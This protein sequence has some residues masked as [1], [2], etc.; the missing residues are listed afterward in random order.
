MG[1]SIV[2][3]PVLEP[4][5]LAELKKQLEIA[6]TDTAHDM[7]LSRL[8]TRARRVVEAQT[9][10]ALVAQTWLITGP[11]FPAGCRNMW[12]PRPPL[13]SVSWVKYYDAAGIQQTWT[14]AE[15]LVITTST[16]GRVDLHP[17]YSW[18]TVQASRDNALQIQFVAGYGGTAAAVPGELCQAIEALAAFWFEVRTTAEVPD[19]LLRFLRAQRPGSGPEHFDLSK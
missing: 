8:I 17:N 18:P 14:T 12:L 6:A 4:V 1:L 10:R 19:S 7:H 3:H 16:P 11:G 9:R 5:T 15:Y 2:T 13:Q